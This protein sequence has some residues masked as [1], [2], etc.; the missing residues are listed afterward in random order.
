[1]A[2][3]GESCELIDSW[4]EVYYWQKQQ[5]LLYGNVESNFESKR[6]EINKTGEKCISSC[7][8]R[9]A[10]FGGD[11]PGGVIYKKRTKKRG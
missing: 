3:G 4:Y 5:V 8:F 11:Y 6:E 7:A 1:M 10:W 2:K 9:E